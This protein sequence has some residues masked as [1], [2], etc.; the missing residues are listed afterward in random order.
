M[1]LASGTIFSIIFTYMTIG[2]ICSAIQLSDTT[3]DS[4]FREAKFHFSTEDIAY[5]KILGKTAVFC[6]FAAAYA[7]LWPVLVFD[8]VMDW[9]DGE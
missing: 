7:A 8:W 3:G 2:T 1:F 9:L 6:F 4:L 5:A